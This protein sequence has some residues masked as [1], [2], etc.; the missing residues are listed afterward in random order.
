MPDLCPFSL[1]TMMFSNSL[2][3]LVSRLKSVLK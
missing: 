2:M 1:I 3:F